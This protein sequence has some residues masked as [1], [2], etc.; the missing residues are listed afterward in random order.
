MVE[1][2]SPHTKYTSRDGLNVGLEGAILRLTID[3]EKRRNAI[4]DSIIYDLIEILESA[5]EDE[6]VRA[7]LLTGSGNDF[8]S[9]FDLSGRGAAKQRTGA[10]QRR[11][12]SHAHR[13]VSLFYTA[14]VPIVAAVRG[15]AAGIGLHLALAADFCIAS[16]DARLWEP[17]VNR[18]FTPDSG[19][20]WL[21]PRLVGIARAKEL[22]LL[23]D[24]ISGATAAEWGLIYQSVAAAEVGP[25]SEALATRLASGPTIAIGLTK[26]LVHESHASALDPHLAREALALELSTRSD[27]FKEGMTSMAEKRAADF[28]GQ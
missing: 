24:E 8:C 6:A 4:T 11:L 22:L 21:I 15:C 16:D 25:A 19:G 18:G 10:T 9:G 28:S 7:I 2:S 27:D 5:N 23:G 20:T 3:R 1:A 26:T 12:P 13:L 14:Q 17:F